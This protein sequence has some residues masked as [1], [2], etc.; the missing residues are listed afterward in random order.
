MTFSVL[1]RLSGK[2]TCSTSLP[3]TAGGILQPSPASPYPSA[4]PGNVH[5]GPGRSACLPFWTYSLI[6]TADPQLFRTWSSPKHG[7]SQAK[8]RVLEPILSFRKHCFFV[9]WFCAGKLSGIRV[10]GCLSLREGWQGPRVKKGKV[11]INLVKAAEF[12]LTI[13]PYSRWEP[14]GSIHNLIQRLFPRGGFI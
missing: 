7:S 9:F 1:C 12:H 10:I 2:N 5:T 4:Q 14:T 11:E 6:Y 8:P 3:W 13:L